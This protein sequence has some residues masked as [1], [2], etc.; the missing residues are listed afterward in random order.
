[1]SNKNCWEEF[2]PYTDWKFLVASRNSFLLDEIYCI[3]TD[4][5][6]N[7]WAYDFYRK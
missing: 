4:K 1:L 5:D 6:N 7:K 3:G 2:K